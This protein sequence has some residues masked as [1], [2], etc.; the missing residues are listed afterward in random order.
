[1]QA[2]KSFLHLQGTN[3]NSE[4]ERDVLELGERVTMCL[5]DEQAWGAYSMYWWRTQEYKIPG[6]R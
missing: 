3:W 2:H 4:I 1:M 6:C 5:D